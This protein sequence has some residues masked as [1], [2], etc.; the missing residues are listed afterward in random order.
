MVLNVLRL[1]GAD[2]K[3]MLE[4]SFYHFQRTRVR[5]RPLCVG[6]VVPMRCCGL[7]SLLLL[8]VRACVTLRCR[9]YRTSKRSCGMRRRRPGRL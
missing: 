9:L 5:A 2:V 8:L 4:L 3:R 1:E 7:H 6:V